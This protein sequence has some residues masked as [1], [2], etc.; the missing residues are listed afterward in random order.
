M[1]YALTVCLLIIAMASVGVCVHGGEVRAADM[2][3]PI[4]FVNVTVV[5]MESEQ[6]LEGQTVIVRDGLIATIG[7]VAE[8]EVPDD[9][10]Q[11][12][13]QGIEPGGRQSLFTQS[14]WQP[15][16]P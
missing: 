2:G 6:V 1:R 10:V 5:S 12:D 15:W 3:A 14:D 9:A 7:T 13:G 4:A 8:T 16:D 11:I